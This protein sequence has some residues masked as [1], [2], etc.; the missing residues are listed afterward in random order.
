MLKPIKFK[1]KKNLKL[2]TLTSK[3][4]SEIDNKSLE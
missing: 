4:Y 1:N 2:S 3:K